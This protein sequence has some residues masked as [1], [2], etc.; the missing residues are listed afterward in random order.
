MGASESYR[1]IPVARNGDN[2]VHAG[3]EG[4]VIPTPGRWLAYYFPDN[5]I[6]PGKIIELLDPNLVTVL[7]GKVKK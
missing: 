4:K 1:K 3:K 7:Y 6:Y 5:Y 2:G